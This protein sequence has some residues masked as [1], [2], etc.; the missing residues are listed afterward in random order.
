LLGI[1]LTL[2]ILVGFGQFLVKGADW[3]QPLNNDSAAKPTSRADFAGLALVKSFI[4]NTRFSRQQ[5]KT[6]DWR[7]FAAESSNKYSLPGLGELVPDFL[8]GFGGLRKG[9]DLKR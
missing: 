5:P 6:P 8:P 1:Q 4:F 2:Q 3:C 9:W 7:G